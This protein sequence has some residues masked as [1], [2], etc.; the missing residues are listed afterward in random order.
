MGRNISEL[1][2]S[3][4]FRDKLGRREKAEGRRREAEEMRLIASVLLIASVHNE[5]K[6]PATFQQR[7]F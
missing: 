4:S 3:G 1:P 5:I 6:N 2:R 7:G